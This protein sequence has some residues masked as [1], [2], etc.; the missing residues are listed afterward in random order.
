MGGGVVAGM[1]IS[2]C[3]KSSVFRVAAK[4]AGGMSF[5]EPEEADWPLAVADR[6]AIGPFSSLMWWRSAR[7]PN[8]YRAAAAR[9]AGQLAFI[10]SYYDKLL[11]MYLGAAGMDWLIS[12][13]DRY[14]GAMTDIARLDFEILPVCD[15][16]VFFDLDESTWYRFLDRRRRKLDSDPG[17]RRSYET[18]KLFRAASLE[19]CQRQGC[20]FL[21][22]QQVDSGVDD[23][24]AKLLAMLGNVLKQS[25]DKPR[26]NDEQCGPD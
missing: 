14:F 22:F 9:N 13:A 20:T 23:A 3:G 8:L 4:N 5:A 16:L 12:P 2:G 19:F 15:V 1:G 7:V 11:H 10:D 17:F 18:Q 24:A 25:S 6:S 26:G 21:P